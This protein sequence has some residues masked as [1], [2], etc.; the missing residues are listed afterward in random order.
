M[1]A[2]ANT[3]IAEMEEQEKKVNNETCEL[4][5]AYRSGVGSGSYTWRRQHCQSRLDYIFVFRYLSIQ[6]I[7]IEL[8]WALEQSDHA[9][10]SIELKLVKEVTMNPGLVRVNTLILND[11]RSLAKI[12]TDFFFLFMWP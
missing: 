12:K 5:D 7:D 1:E 2:Q 10:V 4:V 11:T 9:S 8:D 3:T 6:I